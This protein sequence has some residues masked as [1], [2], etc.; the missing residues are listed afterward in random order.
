MAYLIRAWVSTDSDI[1]LYQVVDESLWYEVG[2]AYL[3]I[4]KSSFCILHRGSRQPESARI[5]ALEKSL[6]VSRSDEPSSKSAYW[7]VKTV[8]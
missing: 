2:M 5:E 3:K 4:G 7:V 1:C 8:E 6:K